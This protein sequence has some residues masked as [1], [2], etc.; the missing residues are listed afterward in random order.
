[1]GFPLKKEQRVTWVDLIW[2][3]MKE[4]AASNWKVFYLG[5]DAVSVGKGVEVLKKEIPI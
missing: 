3:L 4:A 5:A 1:L 2:P